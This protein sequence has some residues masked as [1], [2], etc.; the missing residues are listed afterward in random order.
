M[1]ECELRNYIDDQDRAP[2]EGWFVD[3]DKQ[4]QA[5]VTI[6]LS[7]LALGNTSNV[8]AV[9][10]GVSELKLNW[11]PGYRIYFGQ[12]GKAIVIL[13]IGGTKRRQSRD[14]SAAKTYWADY[15]NSLGEQEE[16]EELDLALT[17][18]F[19]AFIKSRIE[20]DPGFREALFQEAVQSLL[21]G[22][23]ET[24]RAVLRDYINATIGFEA[25]AEITEDPLEE[26]DAHVR[27]EGQSAG[28]ASPRRDRR[29]ASEDGRASAKYA[30]FPTRREGKWGSV[31][32]TRIRLWGS[33]ARQVPPEGRDAH[34]TRAS[35]S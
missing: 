2:F 27:P 9:G 34:P 32:E 3:L 30:P 23:A 18:S 22:D 25:L 31:H 15:K 13:L 33:R 21:E 17:R 35:R 28:K 29:A 6:A 1:A 19:K 8:E 16:D 24:G 10:E 11:G 26:P 7:R 20:A 14:I 5:K 4:A 12:E